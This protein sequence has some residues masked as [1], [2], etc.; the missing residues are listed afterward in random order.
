MGLFHRSTAIDVSV[1]PTVVVPRQ[2]VTATIS[3][4]VDRVRSARLDWGYTNFF[5]YHWGGHADSADFRGLAEITIETARRMIMSGELFFV[6]R[7]AGALRL[8]ALIVGTAFPVSLAFTSRTRIMLFVLE[9]PFSER[10]IA[11]K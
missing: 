6:E 3:G 8:A 1:S 5:R 11:P 2:T 10:Q 9:K 4:S 7:H